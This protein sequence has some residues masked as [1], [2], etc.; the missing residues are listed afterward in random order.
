MHYDLALDK[1]EEQKAEVNKLQSMVLDA[2][3]S[4]KTGLVYEIPRFI[5]AAR[6][7]GTP[8]LTRKKSK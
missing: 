8:Y 4:A 2:M 5:R 7:G 6:N 1:L 3:G